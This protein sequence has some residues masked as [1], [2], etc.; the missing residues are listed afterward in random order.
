MSI[1]HDSDSAQA[2]P[3]EQAEYDARLR[4]V[5][6]EMERR[7]L[8]LLY[9][10]SPPNLNYLTGY[11]CVCFDIRIPTG[12]AVP[13]DDVPPMFFDTWEQR[14]TWPATIRDSAAVD[15]GQL[16]R[17]VDA[18]RSR[19]WLKGR[20]G[21]E[22]WT[23]TPPAPIK[24]E[25][26]VRLGAHAEVV[27]G[28]WTV[29]RVRL[30]KS[31]KELEYIRTAIAIADATLAAVRDALV[32]GIREIDLMGLMYAEMARHG[33]EEQ[34]I[35][36][37]VH[38]GPRANQMHVPASRREIQQ[39]DLLM[40]DMCA[41]YNRYHGNVARTFSLGEDPF[42]EDV[43]R[44]AAASVPK[45]LETIGPGAPLGDVQKLMDE[46]IDEAGLRPYVYWIGGYSLGI[47]FPPDWVGHVYLDPHEGF[48]THDFV[49][50]YVT[51]YEH[52]LHDDE[53]RVG[54]GFI[55]TLIMT[56][57]GIDIPS[58]SPRLIT[59]V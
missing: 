31:A 2:L 10:T 59:V 48:E 47:A 29:D 5:R 18:L 38:S 1:T 20:V 23:Y 27:P 6:E 50:N 34:A 33:G 53:Q 52:V 36:M 15:Y 4:R 24:D 42:W 54:C 41:S 58:T 19:G 39:G 57:R 32:P 9:V 30:V 49:P 13:L 11:E 44:R 51:N 17:V 22:R 3:F 37:M 55:D 40:I 45:L 7:D 14:A 25:L 46:H 12:L 21:V 43:V 35:R 28:D 16:D 8:D 26:A 56:E